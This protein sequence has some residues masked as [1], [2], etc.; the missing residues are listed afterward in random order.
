L[1]L[2]LIAVL[3]ILLVVI[4]AAVLL[5]DGRPVFYRAERMKDPQNAFILWK[6]RTMQTVSGD[7]GASGGHKAARTTRLGR[8]LRR[9]HLDEIPQIL[10]ILRGDMSFVGP[11][12]PLREYVEQYPEIYASVLK[13]RPGVT[14]LAS[15][16][17]H[18]HE[19][20][21]LK[22]TKSASET[23]GIYRRRC[24]PRKAR[25]DRLYQDRQSRLLDIFVI[26]RTASGFLNH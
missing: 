20:W 23:E 16:A 21:L 5:I 14:G 26:A 7:R 1:A 19:E 12:P 8:L 22:D 9:T 18:R 6:F 10:N 4:A 2:L 15:V 17:F 13:S 11:R 25:L 24:I 3:A